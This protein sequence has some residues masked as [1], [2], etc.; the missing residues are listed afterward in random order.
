MTTINRAFATR[1]Q[2]RAF[3]TSVN[4]KAKAAGSKAMLR[5]PVKDNDGL[6]GFPT[7]NHG[8]ILSLKK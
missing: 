3:R 4:G 1:T 5:E 8:S 2:A 6:W 7:L